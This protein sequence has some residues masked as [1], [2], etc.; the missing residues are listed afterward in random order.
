MILSSKHTAKTLV[1]TA[2]I[3]MLSACSY[4]PKISAPKLPRLSLFP[5][6]YK[7]D[8]EQGNIVSQEMVDQLR[9]GM[10]KRQVEFLMGTPLLKNTFDQDRWDYLYSIQ[11][12]GKKRQQERL[13]VLFENDALVGFS[14]NFLPTETNAPET[15]ET[16]D[17]AEPQS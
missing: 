4:L 7:I 6:V 2:S 12:G 17:G 16:E 13:T 14:G 15:T 10:T 3:L 8:I 9:P 11:P 1:L 5:G